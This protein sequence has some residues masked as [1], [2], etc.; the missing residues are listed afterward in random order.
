MGTF[1]AGAEIAVVDGRLRIRRDGAVIKFVDEVEHVTFSGER[2]R[3]TGQSVVYVT[4]RCVLRLGCGGLVLTEIAPGADLERDLLAKMSFRPQ[5]ATDLHEM[6]AAI[7]SHARLGLAERPPLTLEARVEYRAD[8]DL[9]LLRLGGLAIDAPGD[10]EAIVGALDQRLREIERGDTVI[11]DCDGFELGHPGATRFLQ[12][13][14][15]CGRSGSWA[16]Y[17][18]DTLLRR[19]LGGTGS[20]ADALRPIHRSFPEAIDA[21]SSI[22]VATIGQH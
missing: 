3:A 4:E 14:R 17:C 21:L 9:I 1:T 13:L 11:V 22:R 10:A 20:D 12:L 16:W 8:H 7:F 15:D 19:K 6:D 5:I 2:A 18:S